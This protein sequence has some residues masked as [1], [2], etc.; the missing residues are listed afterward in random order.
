MRLLVHADIKDQFMMGD[1]LLV[2]PVVEKGA[3][4]RKI[5]LPPGKWRADDGEVYIGSVTIEI[6][7]PLSRL[8]YFER[9]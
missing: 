5:V 3:K 8:P 2:A 4:S 1:D 6:P 9:L 7:T